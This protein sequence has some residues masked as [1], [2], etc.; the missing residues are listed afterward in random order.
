MEAQESLLALLPPP[1]NGVSVAFSLLMIPW[2]SQSHHQTLPKGTQDE[3]RGVSLPMGEKKNHPSSYQHFVAFPRGLWCNLA[4]GYM[5]EAS[6][7]DPPPNGPSHPTS[8][9][10]YSSQ[11]NFIPMF[12]QM[13]PSQSLCK[14]YCH[15]CNDLPQLFHNPC[16]K[17]CLP[18]TSSRKFSS[19]IISSY[20]DQTFVS[21][22]LS[23]EEHLSLVHTR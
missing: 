3:K 11:T 5:P 9:S 10:S 19:L 14:C 22:P 6:F 7:L 18:L 21:H 15:T 2:R 17:Y 13:L 12:L 8:S 20:S 23:T 16:S 4:N 1:Q